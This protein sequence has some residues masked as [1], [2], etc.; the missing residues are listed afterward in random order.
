MNFSGSKL[1][2]NDGTY[3]EPGKSWGDKL[4]SNEKKTL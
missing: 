2:L 3:Y 1:V 4:K